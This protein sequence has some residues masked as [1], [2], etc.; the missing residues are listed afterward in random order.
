M[1]TDIYVYVVQHLRAVVYVTPPTFTTYTYF[2]IVVNVSIYTLMFFVG[3]MA[4]KSQEN[5]WE[6]PIFKRALTF[7]FFMRYLLG[8]ESQ[9]QWHRFSVRDLKFNTRCFKRWCDNEHDILSK[10]SYLK[11]LPDDYECPM[12]LS[13]SKRAR[14]SDQ[15][16]SDSPV[17]RQYKVPDNSTDEEA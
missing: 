10:N 4:L 13:Q 14:S 7:V 9:R 8:H 11:D 16:S 17:K 3:S 1:Y 2:E 15:L 6:V 12:S 5:F